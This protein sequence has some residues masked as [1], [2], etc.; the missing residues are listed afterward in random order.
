MLLGS[1]DL[2]GGI[3]SCI[4]CVSF[5]L[6]ALLSLQLHLPLVTDSL[7]H[8]H[9]ASHV[10]SH[11]HFHS[12]THRHCHSHSD[13]HSHSRSRCRSYSV[14]TLTLILTLV[15]CFFRCALLP[16]GLQY[17]SCPRVGL[18]WLSAESGY[19]LPPCI[20]LYSRSWR[21]SAVVG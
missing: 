12:H 8:S 4:L 13:F 15:V 9:S 6:G 3:C 14:L 2:L 5:F 18:Q 11:S 17:V 21:L 19:A 16:S 1:L 7:S 20:S 10:G